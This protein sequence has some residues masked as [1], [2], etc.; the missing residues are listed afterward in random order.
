MAVVFATMLVSIP[1]YAAGGILVFGDSLSAG[2]G[3][4][5][6]DGWVAL[7]EERLVAKDADI[8]VV[9]A[10]VSGETTAGGRSRLAAALADHQPAIVVLE[11]GGND[12]LRALPVAD[13]KDNLTAMI[14]ASRNAQAKVLLLGMRIPANYG[15]TYSD[16]FHGAFNDIAKQSDVAYVPFFLESIA[17]DRRNFQAD[18]I[19]P[20]AAAQ[21][22][23]LDAVWPTLSTLISQIPAVP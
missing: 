8:D 12:G 2:Y 11:L 6:H 3:L 20:N 19:H 10:S 7:L 1:A 18:G 5:R 4:A 14:E 15:K 21:P 9:N 23:M 22:E 16:R 13:M 17:T